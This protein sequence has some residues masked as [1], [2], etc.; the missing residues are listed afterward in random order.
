MILS[1]VSRD[2][3][4]KQFTKLTIPDFDELIM[5]RDYTGGIV[6]IR[7][8]LE[9]EDHISGNDELSKHWKTFCNF[10]LGNY[11]EA[12]N[13]YKCIKDSNT[14]R[15]DSNTLMMNM[16]ICQFYLGMYFESQSIV[17]DIPNNSLKVRLLFHLAHKL[18][19]EDRL[20]E[21][22]GSL[23]LDTVEDQLSLASMHYLRAHYQDAIDIY[24]K[25]LLDKKEFIALN[26]SLALCFYKLDFFDHSQ[27][28][29]DLYLTK[30]PDSI[31][32]IN[33]KACNRFRLTNATA[34]ENELKNLIRI[35]GIF[36][37]DLIMHNLVVFR[38]GEGALQIL[39]KLIDVISEARLNLTIYYLRSGD[40]DKAQD[41]M[42]KILKPSV[43]SEYILKGVIHTL[44]A[45]KLDSREHLKNAGQYFQLVGGSATECDTIG[46]RQCM[47]SAFFLYGQFEEVLVYL[48]SIRSFFVNDDVFNYNY[49]QAKAATGNYKEA[50]DLF[51]QI[52]DP[53]IIQQ[54]SFSMVLCKCYILCGNSEEAWT[55]YM[56]RNSRNIMM[57]QLIAIECYRIGQYWVAAKAFDML[58]K[59]SSDPNPE[60]Y[61]GKRGACIGALYSI[62]TSRAT[63]SPPNGLMDI[64]DLLRESNNPQAD[65]IVKIIRR[66]SSNLS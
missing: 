62:I 26:I 65:T 39:P 45:Q 57:L 34:A 52:T 51:N 53:F 19:D 40:V 12:L 29:L 13:E 54:S 30:Y 63:G 43:P 2:N 48:N 20:L 9:K 6:Y 61:E 35:D 44:L 31:I 37:T 55:L 38:N 15:I 46:G 32:A 16:A 24:K 18:N 21:L 41:L 5:K 17:D 4:G 1:R 58:E 56:S 33:L 42:G 66:F 28:A 23:S 3:L 7:T 27:E 11:K 8:L 47:A 49:A 25:I 50:I 59:L 10:H 14:S 22:H 64:C 36:G 60:Y